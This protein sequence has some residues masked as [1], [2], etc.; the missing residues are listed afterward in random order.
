MEHPF[1]HGREPGMSVLTRPTAGPRE[2]FHVER[3]LVPE[4]PDSRGVCSTASA[5]SPP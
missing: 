4:A 2:I 3:L 1:A 5:R